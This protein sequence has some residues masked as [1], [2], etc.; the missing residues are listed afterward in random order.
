MNA[1]IIR[2]AIKYA[3]RNS[4]FE[5]GAAAAALGTLNH[6]AT[7]DELIRFAQLI[8]NLVEGSD[9]MIAPPMDSTELARANID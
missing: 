8:G 9:R 3:A 7:D 5:H 1:Q 6:F 4:A 2:D